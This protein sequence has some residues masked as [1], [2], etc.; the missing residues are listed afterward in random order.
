MAHRLSRL[1]LA[2][3]VVSVRDAR[4]FSLMGREK[5]HACAESWLA[6]AKATTQANQAW[7]ASL[8]AA[9]WRAP[10]A[11]APSA[12]ALALQWQR[13]AAGVLAQGLVP[14]H[15]RATRNAKRLRKTK[16]R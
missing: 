9:M 5:S 14:V 12:G 8:G 11:G 2:G 1:A 7:L 16:L 10:L 15:R 4:E 6:M 13:V 3:P